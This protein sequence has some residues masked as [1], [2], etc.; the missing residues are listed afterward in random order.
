[1]Y[2]LNYVASRTNDHPLETRI[3]GASRLESVIASAKSQFAMVKA[4]RPSVIGFYV[5]DDSGEVVSRWYADN[6]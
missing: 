6:E 1:M 2:S 4:L 5:V 3:S